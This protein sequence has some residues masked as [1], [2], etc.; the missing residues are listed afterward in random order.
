MFC[1]NIMTWLQVT[2][3]SQ[4]SLL[5]LDQFLHPNLVFCGHFV[6]CLRHGTGEQTW[7][8]ASERSRGRKLMAKIYRDSKGVWIQWDW[9][10]PW[11]FKVASISNQSHSQSF[12]YPSNT[13][14]NFPQTCQTFIN[15]IQWRGSVLLL[16]EFLWCWRRKYKIISFY[17]DNFYSSVNLGGSCYSYCVDFSK[18]ACVI[19]RSKDYCVDIR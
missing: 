8:A 16:R 1:S 12:C 7:L 15:H 9:I 4:L 5:L 13:L 19:F 2:Y 6:L 11:H 17:N 10:S 3:W 18:F 14:K